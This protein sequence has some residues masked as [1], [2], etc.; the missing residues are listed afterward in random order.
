MTCRPIEL[1]I[2][3]K[4]ERGAVTPSGEPVAKTFA[5]DGLGVPISR[6]PARAGGGWPAPTMVIETPA[7]RTRCATFHSMLEPGVERIAGRTQPE[8]ISNAGART[9]SI[10]GGIRQLS[11]D[12]C[13]RWG[14]GGPFGRLV[15]R[16]MPIVISGMMKI[17]SIT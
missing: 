15:S 1:S 6:K 7:R 14:M 17:A 3:T 13:D 16:H 9:P 8:N 5:I 4:R 10:D 12:H 2:S 11:L